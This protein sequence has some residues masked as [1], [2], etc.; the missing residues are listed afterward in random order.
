MIC[1]VQIRIEYEKW[2][3]K[4]NAVVPLT[5]S[6]E[7][8]PAGAEKTAGYGNNQTDIEAN[9][10]ES[11]QTMG[12]SFGTVQIVLSLALVSGILVIIWLYIR[13]FGDFDANMARLRFHVMTNAIIFNVIPI[14]L[15]SR[16]P[17]M[18]KYSAKIFKG[19]FCYW[20]NIE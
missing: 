19:L 12:Y 13:T 14:I 15:V 6:K 20:R 18:A 10:D 4:R 8:F 16:K 5:S 3:I 9:N 7:T 17:S 11:T 1:Y 2:K